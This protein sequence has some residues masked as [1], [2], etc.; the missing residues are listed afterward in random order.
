M[1]ILESGLWHCGHSLR[2]DGSEKVVAAIKRKDK[3]CRGEEVREAGLGV[4]AGRRWEPEGHGWLGFLLVRMSGGAAEKTERGW[5]E[6]GKW[7]GPGPQDPFI[8][9]TV[10]HLLHAER[11]ARVTG[12]L[13][14]RGSEICPAV[15]LRSATATPAAKYCL[16][17]ALEAAAARFGR[18]STTGYRR[19]DGRIYVEAPAQGWQTTSLRS[20]DLERPLYWDSLG[21]LGRPRPPAAQGSAPRPLYPL[22]EVRQM[23]SPLCPRSHLPN[24]GHAVSGPSESP[25]GL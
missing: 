21:N 14:L 17:G 19:T 12:D 11:L 2:G 1:C 25:G 6:R 24:R 22:W 7:D 16:A 4:H 23:A 18:L 13:G 5:S 10:E 3:G 20:P 8:P 9:Q 15:H